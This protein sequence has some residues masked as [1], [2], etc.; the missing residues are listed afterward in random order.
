MT[1]KFGTKKP[2][3]LALDRA[4]SLWMI[5]LIPIGEHAHVLTAAMLKD[6][7]LAGLSV[8]LVSLATGFGDVFRRRFVAIA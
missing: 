7:A 8:D 2:G 5:K 3:E 1:F 6:Y 4:L